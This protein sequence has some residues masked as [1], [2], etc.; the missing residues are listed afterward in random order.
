MR[1]RRRSWA[2]RAPGSRLLRRPLLFGASGRGVVCA[3]VLAA[4]LSASALAKA[5]ALGSPIL[6]RDGRAAQSHGRRSRRRL[7][8]S[9]LM[10]HRDHL[11]AAPGSTVLVAGI[12]M[13]ARRGSWVRLVARTTGGWRTLAWA[14]TRRSGRFGI[15]YRVRSSERAP[16]RVVFAGS[17]RARPAS[18]S[19]GSLMTLAPVVASWYYDGGNTACGFHA[20]YGI[21]SRTLPCG[22][23]VTLYYAG[24]TVVA[25]VDDRGP[26]VY[27]RTLDLNQNTAAYL[28][29]WGVGLVYASL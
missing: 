2:Y 19:A 12:L 27:G 14:R 29:M 1:A 24:R 16:I 5:A 7:V 26:Y 25:T 9:R 17:R 28:G 3:A 21:A 22:T 23:K 20:T 13:P 18:A 11:T 4:A 15:R 8:P 6:G 10:V